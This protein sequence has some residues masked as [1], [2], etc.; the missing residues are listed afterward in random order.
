M[1]PVLMCRK[2]SAKQVSV[3]KHAKPSL[4]KAPE[5]QNTPANIHSVARGSPLSSRGLLPAKPTRASHTGTD[6]NISPAGHAS[7]HTCTQEDVHSPDQTASGL[8]QAN[9]GLGLAHA[10]QG[11]L[12]ASPKVL[13]DRQETANPDQ[14]RLT[15]PGSSRQPFKVLQAES[16]ELK[17]IA[18]ASGQQEAQEQALIQGSVPTQQR[19]VSGART[20]YHS[21]AQQL[22][23]ATSVS[24]PCSSSGSFGRLGSCQDASHV[25]HMCPPPISS[26]SV[27]TAASSSTD[28]AAHP[29]AIAEASAGG[30]GHRQQTAS[31]VGDSSSPTVS[32]AAVASAS[33]GRTGLWG[34][35]PSRDNGVSSKPSRAKAGMGRAGRQNKSKGASVEASLHPSSWHCL[36]AYS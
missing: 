8:R 21:E 11:R 15:D 19:L 17:A 13:D 18:G 29:A 10:A 35:A 9:A 33:D 3:V 22:S 6:R 14:T 24:D 25:S 34:D 36:A 5:D 31:A 23:N 32:R 26:G 27:D 30:S 2:P 1:S 7:D 12:N 20:H 4:Q 16:T 28:A